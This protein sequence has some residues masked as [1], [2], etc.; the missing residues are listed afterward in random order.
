LRYGGRYAGLPTSTPLE[1]AIFF[2]V[3]QAGA[4]IERSTRGA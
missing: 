1:E 3:D 2:S 4:A